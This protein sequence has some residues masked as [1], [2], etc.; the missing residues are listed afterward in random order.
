MADARGE[1]ILSDGVIEAI[2][3][4]S[5]GTGYSKYKRFPEGLSFGE[6]SDLL[7]GLDYKF[8]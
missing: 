1:V 2:K 8:S 4:I 3:I 5:S 6:Q 7:V